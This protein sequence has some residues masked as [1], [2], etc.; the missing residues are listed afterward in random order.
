MN[1]APKPVAPAQQQCR[2]GNGKNY[3]PRNPPNPRGWLNHMNVEQVQKATDIVLG[4][5][6]Q[7][8]QEFCLILELHILLLRKHLPA[9]VDCNR[10]P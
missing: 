6:P 10:H 5:F 7:F 3:G 8:L 9:K 4:M 1:A 2:D